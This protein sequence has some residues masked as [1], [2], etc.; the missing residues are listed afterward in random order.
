M[1]LDFKE[2]KSLGQQTDRQ[3]T[4]TNNY[5][6]SHEMTDIS[7]ITVIA[8][9]TQGSTDVLTPNEKR[10]PISPNR[11][12]VAPSGAC[13]SD[14]EKHL[15]ALSKWKEQKKSLDNSICKGVSA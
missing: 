1:K 11:V 7:A 5:Q 10:I 2:N 9:A 12:A 14:V 6:L 13:K 3:K 4:Y 8:A 15:V